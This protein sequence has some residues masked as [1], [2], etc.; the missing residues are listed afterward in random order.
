MARYTPV[1]WVA[2]LVV[3]SIIL[4]LASS[5]AEGRIIRVSQN[6]PGPSRDGATWATAYTHIQ[7]G[8][9][10]AGANDEVWVAKGI[11]SEDVTVTGA[12]VGLYGG[13]AG[14]ETDR[15]QRDFRANLSE[16]TVGWLMTTGAAGIS[17]VTVSGFSLVNCAGGITVDGA[18]AILSDNVISGT[19]G[20]TNGVALAIHGTVTASNNVITGNWTSTSGTIYVYQDGTATITRN[21][22]SANQAIQGAGIYV[23]GTAAIADNLICDN[24]SFGHGGA[25]Y[26]S[27][28][29]A[30]TL[31]NNTITGNMITGGDGAGL[32]ADGTASVTNCIVAYNDSGLGAGSGASLTVAN[33]DLYGNTAWDY[34]GI[35]VQTGSGGNI[36]VDPQFRAAGDYHLLSS[37]QCINAGSDAAVIGGACDLDGLPRIVG[38][39]V[40]IGA[41]EYV[42]PAKFTAADTARALRVSGGLD[43][44]SSTDFTFLNAETLGNSAPQIDIADAVRIARKVAGLDINP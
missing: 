3:P 30:A 20:S 38:P 4:G 26:V 39:H 22:I 12:G 19:N 32:F 10:V 34:K 5:G 44:V 2:V 21:V 40:D 23:E 35:T 16:I 15:S 43:T 27:S 37:S 29:G 31:V 36:S 42:A 25:V 9:D 14:T 11:Y 13:F 17:P 28:G 33:S 18:S 1:V 8:L 6:A 24:A 7:A 41:Y